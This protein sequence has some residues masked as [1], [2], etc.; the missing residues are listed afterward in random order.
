MPTFVA[1][2]DSAAVIMLMNLE[3]RRGEVFLDY[4]G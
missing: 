4:L 2:K 3:S 1:K